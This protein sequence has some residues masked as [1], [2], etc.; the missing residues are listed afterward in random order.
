VRWSEAACIRQKQEPNGIN[1]RHVLEPVLPLIQLSSLTAEQLTIHVR[2]TGI[3]TSDELL[4]LYVQQTAPFEPASPVQSASNQVCL[5][6]V[7][8]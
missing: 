5:K 3:L 8:H 7:M 2:P 1:K 4:A 6:S